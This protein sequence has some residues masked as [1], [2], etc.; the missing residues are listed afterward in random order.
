MKFFNEI[1]QIWAD[2][3]TVNKNVLITDSFFIISV[4]P[5]PLI[6]CKQKNRITN[7]PAGFVSYRF[8]LFNSAFFPQTD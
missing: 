5:T 6:C 7:N 3:R 2:I 4:N 1:Q 8:D